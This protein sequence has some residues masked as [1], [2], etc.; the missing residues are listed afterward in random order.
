MF[1][2]Y[3]TNF[4]TRFPRKGN[5]ERTNFI[6]EPLFSFSYRTFHFRFDYIITYDLLSTVHDKILRFYPQSYKILNRTEIEVSKLIEL[7]I[8]REENTVS[9]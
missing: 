8:L 4:Q 3:F 6:S 1:S 9:N 5:F 2:R 7:V